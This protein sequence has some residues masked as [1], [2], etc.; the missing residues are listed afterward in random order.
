MKRIIKNIP[1]AKNE[2]NKTIFPKYIEL[3]NNILFFSAFVGLSFF[4]VMFSD[5]IIQNFIKTIINN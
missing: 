3:K 1:E 2:L 5:S 4:Y